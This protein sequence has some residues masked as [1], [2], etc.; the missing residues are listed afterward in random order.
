MNQD[1]DIKII[2]KALS[3]DNAY[4]FVLDSTCGGITLFVGTV[5]N[6]NKG[7]TV[8]HLDF[9]SYRPM[10]IKELTK[11]AASCQ[12]QFETKKIAIYH[13]EGLVSIKEKAVIIAVS[14]IHRKQAFLACEFIIDQLKLNVPIW[15]KEYLMDG[16]HWVNARP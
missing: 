1:F 8:T 15:K 11:I 6:H 5:R 7:E 3:I 12:T 14:T 10:A 13:R 9:E 16:S 4:D 2:N